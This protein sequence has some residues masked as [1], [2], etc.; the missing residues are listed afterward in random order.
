MNGVGK[1][2]YNRSIPLTIVNSTGKC[3]KMQKGNVLEKIC[4][5]SEIRNIH[6][7]RPCSQSKMPESLLAYR[8]PSLPDIP[9]DFLSQILQLH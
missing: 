3:F 4:A 8:H 7:S 1:V 5:V 2:S 9:P 6:T